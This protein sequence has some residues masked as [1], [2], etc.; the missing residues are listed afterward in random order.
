MSSG[1]LTASPPT[2][3]VG[4]T[5]AETG[6]LP[7][8]AT[9]REPAA[10]AGSARPRPGCRRLRTRAPP[11]PSGAL[12]RHAVDVAAAAAVPPPP[13][14][15]A[16]GHAVRGVGG[17]PAGR[18]RRPT[19]RDEPGR[20]LL[21]RTT[22]PNAPGSRGR[23]TSARPTDAPTRPP[24]D[25]ARRHCGHGRPPRHGRRAARRSATP[26]AHRHRPAAAAPV[27][28]PPQRRRGRTAEAA[29]TSAA[30]AT[31]RC[32]G[33]ADPSSTGP[34][35]TAQPTEGPPGLAAGGGVARVGRSPDRRPRGPRS[36]PRR[37]PAR[38]T[39][40]GSPAAVTAARRAPPAGRTR[41]CRALGRH[42]RVP[43]CAEHTWATAAGARRGCGRRLPVAGRRWGRRPQRVL[44]HVE[45]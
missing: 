40:F 12:G 7:N 34:C 18:Q 15:A 45:S 39:P 30:A 33:G 13:R 1:R 31:C 19:R 22:A 6:A 9:P 29:G 24:I 26:T 11:A 28:P 16:P 36:R 3:R 25:R 37:P 20:G 38:V 14:P 21:Q 42:P 27:P 17:A 2:A 4:A 23:E 10:A 41:L 5:L 32:E 43:A 44:V 35:L 8:A